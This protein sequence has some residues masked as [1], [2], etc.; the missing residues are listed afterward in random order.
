MNNLLFRQQG[1]RWAKRA[2]EQLGLDLQIYGQGWDAH[3]EFASHAHGPIDYGDDL[4]ELTRHSG[5][6][7]VLEPF[8]C[9]SH[10]RF[11]DAMAAGGFCLVRDNPANHNIHSI[12]ELLA[13]AGGGAANAVQLL[14]ALPESYHAQYEQT[15]TACDAVDSSPGASDHVAIVRALQSCDLLPAD[16]MMI[17]MLDRT[18]FASADELHQRLSRFM[19]D[20]GLRSQIAQAQRRYVEQHFSYVAGIR[21]VVTFI[22]ARL[23]SESDARSIAA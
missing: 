13:A 19:R 5:I 8:V 18:T 10:Q 20:D 3:P 21:Q 1:L 23:D 14:E 4:E 2:C 6:N 16:G 11:L 17:P 9:I 7:L 22:R 15:I 12:I